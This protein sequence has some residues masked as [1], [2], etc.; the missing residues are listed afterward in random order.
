MRSVY[1]VIFTPEDVGYSVYVPDFDVNTQ[2]DDFAEA[3]YMA[4]EVIGLMGDMLED[5]GS[6]MPSPSKMDE[7]THAE[8]E[9][10]V[11]IDVDFLDYRRRHDNKAVK[12][13]CSI[14]NWLNEAAMQAG[15]NFSKVLQDGLKEKLGLA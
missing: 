12:K 4:R 5:N 14:P 9:S 8:N 2:G 6:S 1:P 7:L 15:L 3:M 10:V 13:N 11:L